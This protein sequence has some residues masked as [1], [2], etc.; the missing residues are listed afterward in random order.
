MF[1]LVSSKFFAMHNI[2]LYSVYL[3]QG[4][5][6]NAVNS[7]KNVMLLVESIPVL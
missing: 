4:I 2:A 1:F 3:F 7:T 5:I 6:H